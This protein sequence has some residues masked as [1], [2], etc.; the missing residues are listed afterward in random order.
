MLNT[1]TALSL[2]CPLFAQ[3]DINTYAM[4]DNEG[5]EIVNRLLMSRV[6]RP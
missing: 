4:T 2:F 1:Y 6:M 5:W 3:T